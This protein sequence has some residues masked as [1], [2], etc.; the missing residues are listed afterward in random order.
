MATVMA[1]TGSDNETIC[2]DIAEFRRLKYFFGQMLGAPD[3]QTEQDYFR[4]KHKL[5]NRC[6][7]GYG[8]VCGL[9]VKPVPFPKECETAAEREAAEMRAQ[10]A[11]LLEQQQA[12]AAVPPPQPPQAAAPAGAAPAPAAPAPPPA[13]PQAAAPA[14]AAPAP[15]APAPAAGAAPDLGAQIE[16]L[17][18][19]LK[20]FC[21]EHCIEEPHTC[22]EIECGLA[23]D[24]AGNELIVRRPI[25]L[26]LAQ[27]LSSSDYQRV[28]QGAHALYVSL[29]Y[30]ERPVD[31]V[32]PV[33]TDT[34]GASPQCVY[35][36]LQ[37]TVQVTVSVE[38]PPCDE[39][40]GTCCEPCTEKCLLLAQIVRFCPGHELH[41]HQIHNHVR[42]PISLYWPTQIVGVS[43]H[44]GR[45][46]TQDEAMELMGTER[47]DE[48]RGRGLEVRFSRPVL[49]SSIR[50]GVMETWVIEE[51]GR[52]RRG[53]IYYKQGHFLFLDEHG[54]LVDRPDKAAVERIFY[55]DS[56]DETLE[57]GDRV[58]V[59]VHSE[60]ILD[61]CC[62]PVDGENVGGRVPTLEEYV[63]RFGHHEHRGPED[64]GEEE[65]ERHEPPHCP[66]CEVP[67]VG[68]LPWTSGNGVPGGT[69][70]GWFYIR[71][72]EHHREH[73]REHRHDDRPPF[74]NR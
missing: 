55:R 27:C 56:T 1:T 3:L 58:L 49:A 16:A 46:Y 9:L 61:E 19:R 70:I 69:F 68:Y 10:L 67:P 29:C 7:H 25:R 71:E 20:E 18:R 2:L 6:L 40:C 41:A 22:I 17:R 44:Q 72:N 38:R 36:K 15:A 26:D 4:G 42:R 59:I 35:G 51:K 23:L 52:G 37:D 28:L 47:H 39:R 48:R 60:F 11:Q 33:L 50:P 66:E 13:Q 64:H 73:H 21:R 43:W 5:H 57:P 8:V 14:G 32:R 63:H 30:C 31:P 34:C 65:G 62:R 12:Q 24:C 45:H 54:H 53:G 74:R